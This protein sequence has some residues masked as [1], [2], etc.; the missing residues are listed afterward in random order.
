MDTIWC[1]DSS[2]YATSDINRSYHFVA[3]IQKIHRNQ[4][5]NK[6]CYR[7]PKIRIVKFNFRKK[8]VKQL[9]GCENKQVEVLFEISRQKCSSH[10][11]LD[12]FFN[13]T[14]ELKLLISFTKNKSFRRN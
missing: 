11:H 3:C 4:I 9:V 10:I 1:R 12:F 6:L 8:E 2:R 13:R 7:R 5:L 14:I